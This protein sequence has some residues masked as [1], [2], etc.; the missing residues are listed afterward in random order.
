MAV[1]FANAIRL[2]ESYGVMDFLLPF[3]LIFTLLYVLLMKVP[4]FQKGDENTPD[5]KIVLV[6]ATI[7]SLLVVAPH[8]TNSYPAGL[9]PINI[10]NETLPSIALMVVAIVFLL[11]LLGAMGKE[12]AQGLPKWIES[13][14]GFM[15]VV[16]I[17][18]VFGTSLGWWSA[19]AQFNANLFGWWSDDL[20]TLLVVILVFGLIGWFITK[21]DNGDSID[22]V[23][24]GKSLMETLFG[25]N[26]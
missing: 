6:I 10:L 11:I 5:K 16:F 3:F 1:D 2:L 8:I 15:A 9:D 18:Y 12:G 24:K 20:T 26:Q 7:L 21:D 17:V 4:L 19:P 25:R 23:G 14:F 13:G 22:F